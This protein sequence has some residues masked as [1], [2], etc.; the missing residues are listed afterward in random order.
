MR[1]LQQV[2]DYRIIRPVGGS[3]QFTVYRAVAPG[4]AGDVALKVAR[5]GSVHDIAHLRRELHVTRHL[6]MA[7]VREVYEV[8]QSPEGYMYAAM[9]WAEH[10]LREVM[11]QRERFSKNETI[12]YLTPVARTLD[13]L[14]DQGYVHTDVTP[15][16]ILLTEDGRVLLAGMA[17][18][19]RRGQHP[20]KCDPRY[21]APDQ[22]ARQPV[23]PWCDIY[24]LGV[25]AYEM[26]SGRL[27]FEADSNE[28]W[29]RAHAC[30]MPEIP[31]WLWRS[32]GR[33]AS[34]SLLRALAKEPA[35]RFYSATLFLESLKE[36]EPTSMRLQLRLADLGMTLERLARRAPRALKLAML[37]AVLAAGAGGLF[38]LSSQADEEVEEDPRTATAAIVAAMQTPDTIWTPRPLGSPSPTATATPVVTRA[39]LSSEA[40]TAESAASEAPTAT[41]EPVTAPETL[42]PAPVL[43][44]PAD[45]TRF[46]MDEVVDLVWQ[47]DVPLEPGESFDVRMWKKGE[48]PWGIARTTE[49]RYHL[50]HAPNGPGEYHWMIVVVRDDPNSGQVIETSHRSAIQ[51]V[52]WG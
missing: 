2:G 36:E 11:R 43:L 22:G 28:E 7:G 34:R 33:D 49:T 16:H 44:Q 35:D 14:H 9:E 51:R 30:F 40:A 18:T 37:V 13:E 10:S 27:P 29:Q 3:R 48:P 19:R 26:L 50:S 31:R 42:H 39:T 23:G 38:L 4:R 12:A 24:S 52:F 25:I 6:E 15:E 20:A 5:Q 32:L 17:R 1:D 41:P 21:R 47:Y 45:V 46:S 8:S